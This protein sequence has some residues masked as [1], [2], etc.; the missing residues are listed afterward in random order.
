MEFFEAE[1]AV[2]DHYETN[3]V[4]PEPTTAIGRFMK[5]YVF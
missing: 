4:F 1:R 2:V 3:T 5:N